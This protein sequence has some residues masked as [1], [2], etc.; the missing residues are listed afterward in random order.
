MMEKGN[1]PGAPRKRQQITL[2]ISTLRATDRNL[3]NALL[4]S[5][6]FGL[7][8]LFVKTP[9]GERALIASVVVQGGTP[10]KCTEKQVQTNT[11]SILI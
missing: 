1:C 4:G 3:R 9:R 6:F 8:Q 10:E 2:A 7:I 5:F 11:E